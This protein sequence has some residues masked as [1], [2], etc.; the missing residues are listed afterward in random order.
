MRRAETTDSDTSIELRR[1]ETCDI[2]FAMRL[3]EVADW[4]QLPEDWEF[5]L[6][7]GSDGNLVAMLD[8]RPAGTVTTL[9]YGDRFSWIGMVLVDPQMRRRGVGTRLLEAA[10]ER[11][12]RHGDVLLDATPEGKLLYETLGFVAGQ[13]IQRL[14]REGSRQQASQQQASRQQAS[15]QQASRQQASQ[16]QASQQQASRQQFTSVQ[17]ESRPVQQGSRPVQQGDLERIK[18]MDRHVFGADRS[19]VLN[20]LLSRAPDY[21][22]CLERDGQIRG[23][24]FGRPGSRFDQIGPL[25]AESLDGAIALLSRVIDAAG[26]RPL[27]MDVFTG[28]GAWPSLLDGFGFRFQRRLIRMSLEG[29]RQTGGEGQ[30]ERGVQPESEDPIRR[31]IRSEGEDPI[32]RGIRSESSDPVGSRGSTESEKHP[33]G[34]RRV[35]QDPQVPEDDAA[36]TDEHQRFGPVRPLI[37]YAIAAPEWG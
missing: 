16:Q 8:G 6:E 24:C 10:I 1:M 25:V 5:L 7:A 4:N 12:R 32:G 36:E 17:Q 30:I 27:V 2:P 31:G 23:Y 18:A 9:T 37:S 26:E 33:E 15:R 22:W 21:G 13:E 28:D 14:E 34:H 35:D 19:S 3:K 20:Y 29:G 11:A